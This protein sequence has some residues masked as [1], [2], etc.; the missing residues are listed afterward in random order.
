MIGDLYQAYVENGVVGSNPLQL[1]IMMYETAIVRTQEARACLQAGD[2][3]G[4]ARA[5]SK[6][7]NILSELSASLNPEIGRE[8][9]MNL[10]RLYHYMQRRLQEA[11]LKKSAEPLM[12]VERLLKELLDAWYKA[13]AAER[14][15]NPVLQVELEEE[16]IDSYGNYGSEAG[17]VARLGLS[18]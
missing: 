17:T 7:A 11:H 2:V 5:I 13:A 14:S 1:V 9:G 18:A 15:A 4:R 6:A 8:I 16:R 10:D 12:E 3:W